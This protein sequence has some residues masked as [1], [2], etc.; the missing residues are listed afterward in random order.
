MAEASATRIRIGRAGWLIVAAAA[1]LRL[2]YFSIAEIEQPF[3]GDEGQYF[4]IAYNVVHSQTFS[5]DV[6]TAAGV[7]ADS[8]RAPGYPLLVAAVLWPVGDFVSAYRVVLVIQC[9]LGAATVLLCL[10][11]G[12]RMLTR[13]AALA[14]ASLAAVWP[15]LITLGDYAL[16]E[17]LFGFLVALSAWLLVLALEVDDW[18]RHAAAGIA[19]AA[20][21]LVNQILLGF[22]LLLCLWLGL[23]RRSWGA[24]V[25]VLFA[26]APPA[27]WMVR[28]SHL[29]ASGQRS[30][31]VRLM[32]N[33]LIGMEPD[34]VPRYAENAGD[35]AGIA[36]RARIADG[37]RVFAE[38][39]RQA[40]ADVVDR[41]ASDPW[42]M[43]G[44]YATKP[45]Q[46][47]SWSIVQGYGD[48]YVYTM[49]FAP[50]D[51]TPP[52]RL[53][54][55]ICH[56]LNA[57]IMAAAFAGTALVALRR[58][59]DTPGTGTA[60]VI[61]AAVFAYA[62]LVHTVLTPDVRYAVPF[63]AFE[64]LMAALAIQWLWQAAV[65]L[66]AVRQDSRPAAGTVRGA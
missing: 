55:A 35:P 12:L 2:W 27:L 22:S 39:P 1:L 24:A 5:T 37:Q 54:A 19:L 40:F 8:Y 45:A 57:V 20:A 52:L 7:R 13:P 16:T 15:H 3:R 36:A 26:L 43:L 25:L 51:A 30:G 44:W 28:D 49:R 46:F 11:L 60:A 59:R 47:W 4:R 38:N 6:P 18:R 63:R 29:H 21:A 61:V 33:V 34:F 23:R 56:G 48:V 50:F 58:R 64:F 65:R 17:T 42:R 62:T 32:E 66:R 10:L 14:A 31:A 9:L 41:L 53:L